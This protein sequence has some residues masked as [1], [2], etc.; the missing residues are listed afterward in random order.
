METVTLRPLAHEVLYEGRFSETRFGL[1]ATPIPIYKSLLEHLG[2]EGAE[3]SSLR[4]D[5]ASLATANVACILGKTNTT[6][7]VRLDRFEIACSSV[8]QS[9]LATVMGIIAKSW[10]ALQEVDSDIALTQHT[11]LVASYSAIA[12]F[13]YDQMML[14]YAS[15]DLDGA[16][17]IGMAFYFPEDMDSGSTPGHILFDRV[18]SRNDMALVKVSIGFSATAVSLNALP[19]RLEEYVTKNLARLGIVVSQ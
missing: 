9:N 11:I 17:S 13:S 7:R 2:E 16:L 4:N 15:A 8:L 1:L 6:V 18:P 19:A 5:T 14:R 10:A 12:G 3:L